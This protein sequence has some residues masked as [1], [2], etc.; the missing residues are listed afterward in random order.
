MIGAIDLENS[1]VTNSISIV[2]HGN[3]FER[4]ES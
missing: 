4:I 1:F 2:L 3:G